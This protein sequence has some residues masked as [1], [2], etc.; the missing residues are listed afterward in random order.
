M[1]GVTKRDAS[2]YLAGLPAP[3]LNTLSKPKHP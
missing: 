2:V 1:G 3:T